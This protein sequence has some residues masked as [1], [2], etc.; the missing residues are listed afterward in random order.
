MDNVKRSVNI[1]VFFWV[2]ISVCMAGGEALAADYMAPTVSKV[3]DVTVKVGEEASFIIWAASGVPD[4]YEYQWYVAS[5]KLEKGEKIEGATSSRYVISAEEVTMDLDGRYYY[6]QV[7]NGVYDVMSNYA[8]LTV[9]EEEEIIYVAPTV[10]R[11]NDVTVKSGEGVTFSVQASQG[12]PDAYTYQWH[13]AQGISE[14][15]NEIEGAVTPRLEIPANEVTAGLNGRYY[16][17]EVSNGIY[18]VTSNRARLIVQENSQGNGSISD[19]NGSGKEENG[20]I[21]SGNQIEIKDQEI[22]GVKSFYALE[23]GRKTFTLKA[24]S[25]GNG[26]LSYNSSNK[27]VAEVS[28]KGKVLIKSCGQTT[29]TVKASKTAAYRKAQKKVKIKI[30]PKAVEIKSFTSPYSEWVEL[31]WSKVK[32]VDKYEIE[33]WLNSTYKEKMTLQ[34]GNSKKKLTIED[35]PSGKVFYARL[36]TIK[37]VKKKPYYSP[38]SKKKKVRVK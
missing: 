22:L 9:E 36:R 11:L 20:N 33:I 7:S 17:C 4:V 27:K 1:F 25:N 18:H 32:A 21:G 34:C 31:K 3:P 30:R 28:S 29:I 38:W 5:S 16:Y 10:S 14:K 26:E 35:C 13:W 15:G 37:Y 23:Y 12:V 24:K 2:L 8:L 6:C 19:N